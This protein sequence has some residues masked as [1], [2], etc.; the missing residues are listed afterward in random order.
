MFS[1]CVTG[2]GQ[3]TTAQ[4]NA[5]AHFQVVVV[6]VVVCFHI[7]FSTLP[8][9]APARCLVYRKPSLI[10]SLPS[11]R[12]VS[13]LFFFVNQS[14]RS[15]ALPPTCLPLWLSLVPLVRVFPSRAY[16]PHLLSVCCLLLSLLLKIVFF[17]SSFSE[18]LS[19]LFVALFCPM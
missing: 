17:F 9:R 7:E 11:C 15:S 12:F 19:F 13:Y 18:L 2:H 1:N 8:T 5:R 6:V 10:C 16:V 14:G 3:H 4:Q